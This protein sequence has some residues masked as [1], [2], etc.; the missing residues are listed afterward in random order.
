VPG[1]HEALPRQLPAAE[2]RVIAE[3]I[4]PDSRIERSIFGTDDPAAI[5]A[6]VLEV[7]PEAV[8]CFAFEVSVGARFGL[9]LRD[10]SRIALKVHVGR[11]GQEY[12]EVV[13][14]V[15]A[16]LREQGFPCPR[17]L[18]VRE[19]ATLEEWV[20]AG[21]YRDAH[22]PEVRRVIAGQLARLFRLTRELGSLRGM[23]PFF[24]PRDGPLWPI[25]H[26]VLFDFEATAG[27]EWIDEI[28]AAAK[29]VRDAQ[30]GEL[31]IGHG[32]WTVKHFRFDGLRPTVIY[33]W[34]SL[35]TDFETIFVGGSAATFTYT[36]HL[37]IRL[38]PTAEQARAFI[39]DYVEAR[40]A[41][42]TPEERRAVEGTAVYSRA[43]SAR[44]THAVGLDA[45]KMDLRE[46]AEAF[47]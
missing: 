27:A 47:L 33:D 31:V 26:N 29:P 10:G 30:V 17:P 25:P 40:G 45:T 24:P 28:A 4:E 9:R 1:D 42:F 37:P 21:V 12:L 6:Q 22:E 41:P 18:G 15:Q 36:E 39:D 7:C 8:G 38:W 11:E 32:D 35:N 23:E 16:H 3:R 19:R 46:Y 2:I 44:C 14:R 43:Y 20:D 34:D 13:Q 5:W